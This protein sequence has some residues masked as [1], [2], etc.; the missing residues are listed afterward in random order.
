MI[1]AAIAKGCT[2]EHNETAS[3]KMEKLANQVQCAGN[4]FK[5]MDDS[6][7]NAAAKSTIQNLC[8]SWRIRILFHFRTNSSLIPYL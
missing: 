6:V 3:Q 4:A 7:G 2:N 1:N 5:H 8:K